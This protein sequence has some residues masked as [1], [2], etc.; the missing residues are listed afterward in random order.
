MYVHSAGWWNAI[1][2]PRL[3]HIRRRHSPLARHVFVDQRFAVG[4]E[5]GDLGFDAGDDALHLAEFGVE[6]GADGYLFTEG[7][8]RD[9]LRFDC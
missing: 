4:G 8:K 5:G 1:A 2:R 6:M 9:E 3:A 7:R